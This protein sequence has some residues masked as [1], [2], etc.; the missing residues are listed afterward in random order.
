MDNDLI[1]VM[2]SKIATE[3][4][5]SFMEAFSVAPK[6]LVPTLLEIQGVVAQFKAVTH[7]E[8]VT[9]ESLSLESL[10]GEAQRMMAARITAN[11]AVKSFKDVSILTNKVLLLR[12]LSIVI[13]NSDL[14]GDARTISIGVT[15]KGRKISITV[16]DDGCGMEAQVKAEA[17]NTTKTY[18]T[19]KWGQSGLPI[20]K[21]LM[22]IMGGDIEISES[23]PKKGTTIL[24]TLKKGK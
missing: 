5:P 24:L 7:P 8:E 10:L 1:W 2:T 14:H 4:A 20:A 6:E 17:F 22:S 23:T 16:T 13:K 19:D 15:V 12:V 11:L 9:V 18:A 3:L 21:R